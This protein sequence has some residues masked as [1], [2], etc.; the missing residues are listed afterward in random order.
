ML[1]IT[2]PDNIK[3]GLAEA[4]QLA[5]VFIG[6][7][8]GECVTQDMVRSMA[9]GAVVFAAANPTPE[10]W[11][12]HAREAGAVVVGTGRSDFPNQLN[13]SLAFPGVFRGALDTRAPRVTTRMKLSAAEALAGLVAEPTAEC[14][15]PWSLDEKVVPAVAHAVARAWQSEQGH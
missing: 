1:K 9:P 6:L 4:M 8:V 15:I 10:I 12:D 11:P 5:D 13:N 7:S 2:N 3:G 14:V